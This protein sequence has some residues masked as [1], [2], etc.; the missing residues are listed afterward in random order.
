MVK[1]NKNEIK[2]IKAFFENLVTIITITLLIYVILYQLY[3]IKIIEIVDWGYEIGVVTYNLS[4]SIIASGVFYYLV[5]YIP[6]K[7]KKKK[8]RQVINYHFEQI[9]I[10]CFLT[11]TAIKNI[12]GIE[13]AP[14][15]FPENIDEFRSICKD[16]LLT[17]RPPDY[18]AVSAL[19]PLN[20]WF[21][22][23]KYNFKYEDKNLE[24]LYKFSNYLEP[25]T[26]QL[27]HDLSSHTF[28]SVIYQYHSQYETH[29]YATKFDSLS[30]ILHYYL[31]TL[32]KFKQDSWM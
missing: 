5:V 20:N 15:N 27:M 11:Y 29:D 24:E 13:N 21:E 9:E 3:L 18:F 26:M 12:S 23:F 7:R 25:D 16:M 31:K 14:A 30:H 28:R 10:N 17:S 2:I 6:E 19:V 4:L 32:L 1:H 22:Y 8:V